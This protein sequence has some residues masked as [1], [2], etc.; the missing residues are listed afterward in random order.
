LLDFRF[1][2]RALHFVLL[3]QELEKFQV[4]DRILPVVAA[5]DHALR[6]EAMLDGVHRTVPLA[7]LGPRARGL[8][9]IAT[10]GLEFLLAD[11][12]RAVRLRLVRTLIRGPVRGVV[13]RLRAQGPWHGHDP[14]AR[15]VSVAEV[16]RFV[17]HFR[18]SVSHV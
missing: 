9:R 3:S 16:D 10:V 4:L 12:L 1:F 5:G 17:G 2:D 18:F 6:Q 8:L 11:R 15:W 14:R 7:F 13:R